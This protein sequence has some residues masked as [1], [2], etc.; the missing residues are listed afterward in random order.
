MKR[1]LS[2]AIVIV[3]LIGI[4][5]FPSIAK[6]E[7]K[8]YCD[9]NFETGTYTVVTNDANDIKELYKEGVLQWTF[10]K[11]SGAT[12][13]NTFPAELVSDVT[14]DTSVP[15]NGS[16]RALT[17]TADAPLADNTIAYMNLPE[18]VTTGTVTISFR[19]KRP[20]TNTDTTFIA[21]SEAISYKR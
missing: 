16:T 4:I 5:Q 11:K 8:T 21:N 13:A 3:M 7:Q 18:K 10:A 12:F 20:A 6:T 19:M 17:T 15:L 2:M 1:L 14:A 9:E